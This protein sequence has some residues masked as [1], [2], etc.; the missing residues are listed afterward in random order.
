MKI[1]VKRRRAAPTTSYEL[2]GTWKVTCTVVR[3]DPTGYQAVIVDEH[4]RI[5]YRS[6]PERIPEGFEDREF[7]FIFVPPVVLP[8]VGRH[9]YRIG[10]LGPSGSFVPFEAPSW[11][12]TH[13]P[14]EEAAPHAHRPDY[15]LAGRKTP[16]AAR[17]DD[18]PF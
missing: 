3:P 10:V 13:Q 2:T 4:N 17:N 16:A 18:V 8:D 11:V 5:L 6:I 14:P 12:P 9:R 7:T 1:K 15:K